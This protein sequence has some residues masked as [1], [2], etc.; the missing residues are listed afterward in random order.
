MTTQ[1][2]AHRV[3]R[4]FRRQ[5]YNLADLALVLAAALT[6]LSGFGYLRAAWPSLSSNDPHDRA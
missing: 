1:S 3:V 4:A 6:L 2:D 5:R